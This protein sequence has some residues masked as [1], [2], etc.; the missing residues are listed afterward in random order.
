MA[1]SLL[2]SL[3]LGTSDDS[4]TLLFMDRTVIAKM[5]PRLSLEM[6]PPVKGAFPTRKPKPLTS[7]NQT[8]FPFK[9]KRL[10]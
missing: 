1:A 4:T 7:Y 2:V 8:P 3:A 6:N 5:D 9:T 10:T